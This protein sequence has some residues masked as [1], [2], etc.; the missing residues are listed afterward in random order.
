MPTRDPRLALDIAALTTAYRDGAHT[1]E[2]VLDALLAA[3]AADTRDINAFCLIDAEGARVQA[4]AAGERWRSGQPLSA[5]DGVP[6]SI[7]DLMNVAGWPTR[8]GSRVSAGDAPAPQDAPCV[9]PLRAAGCVL[10]GKTTTTEFGW[11]IGSTNPHAGTTHHPFDATRS[12]G[13]SSSGA[14]AQVAAGWGP[15]AL[16]SDAGGSVRIP[17]SY[18]GLVGF[19][20]TFGAIPVAPQSAFAEFAHMGP[21]TRSV[22]DAIAA[23]AVLSQS[24]VRD[25][26][27]LFPRGALAASGTRPLRIGWTLQLGAEMQVS[28]VIA[29]AFQALLDRLAAAGHTLVPLPTGSTGTGCAADMWTVWMSRV[30]ESFVTWSD[31]Q[32]EKLGP[33]LQSVYADGAAVKVDALSRS[34]GRLREFSGQLAGAFADFDL[35]L[36]PSTPSVAPPLQTDL[37]QAANWFDDNGFSYPFNLTQQPALSLPLGRDATGLPFGLQIAGRK[38]HDAQVLGFGRT[39]EALLA[40]QA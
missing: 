9:A 6:V 1:P 36:S 37:A 35:L 38:Y 31:A 28:P 8:R 26:S 11:Q 16:G 12:P 34:R 30:H 39:L 18:C 4:R 7:K 3:I 5:L 15:L 10:F 17:A 27:S 19:K 13:G 20:P 32:R 21:L 25:P 23:M 22:D 29:D 33:G 14:A 24:D 40:R 2:A